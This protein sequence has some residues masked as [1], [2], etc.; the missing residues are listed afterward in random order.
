MGEQKPG[1]GIVGA[2][3]MVFNS[4][5][6]ALRAIGADVRWVLDADS[7]R[8]K[9]LAKAY[10]IPGAFGADGLARAAPVD[11]VLLACPYGAR[12]P[13]F[14]YF[15]GNPAALYVEKPVAR[16]VA[17]LER[18]CS[19]RPDYAVAAGFLRR[20]Y[21]VTKIVKGLIEDGIFGALRRVRSEFGTA[22]VISAKSGFAK[23][24]ELAGGGQLFESAIHNIDAICYAAGIERA[25]VR[26]CR[27]EAEANFDLHTEARAELIDSAGRRIELE[28]LVTCF[29]ST[30][31]EIEMEFDRASVTFSLFKKAPPRVRA[32][33]AARS[34]QLLDPAFGDNPKSPFDML[35]VVWR[36]FLAGL[37]EKRANYTS[38]RSTAPAASIIEQVY[39]LGLRSPVQAA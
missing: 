32:H 16:S 31:Y 1:I 6:P 21:G 33:G 10:R 9:A 14:E 15:R 28:L 7:K 26:E 18:I 39:E 25:V 38:A 5:L 11:V 30:Q 13:Y 20:S 37:E 17:E 36:D 12:A 23:N 4:H 24:A 35:Y 2:G 19:G 29:R 8:A 27:M 34:Y 3:A 22:A